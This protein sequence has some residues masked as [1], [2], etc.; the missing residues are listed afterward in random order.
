MASDIAPCIF[1]HSTPNTENDDD[2]GNDSD[3]VLSQQSLLSDN[4]LDY[5]T[6]VASTEVPIHVS[7]LRKT[8]EWEIGDGEVLRDWQ[9]DFQTIY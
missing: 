6:G 7:G 3:G 1:F 5:M 4:D 9:P 2:D 8:S